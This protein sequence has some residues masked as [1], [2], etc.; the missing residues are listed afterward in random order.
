MLTNFGL[1]QEH[2]D[3]GLGHL[4]SIWR[5]CVDDQGQRVGFFFGLL[6]IASLIFCFLV[7]IIYACYIYSFSSSITLYDREREIVYAFSHLTALFLFLL[8]SRIVL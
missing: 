3:Y 4:F 1:K 6:L 8:A 7:H 2:D 5:F